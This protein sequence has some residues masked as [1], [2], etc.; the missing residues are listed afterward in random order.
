LKHF[1]FVLALAVCSAPVLAQDPAIPADTEIVS[2]AS[3]LKYCVLKP[4]D[5]TTKP[6]TGD[7]VKMHYTGWLTNG[8]VFDSSVKRNEPFFF[9]LGRGR[10][11]KGWD[12]AVAL[13]TKGEK[14]KITL[15]PELAYGAQGQGK[16]PANSTLIFEIEFLDIAWTYVPLDPAVK[17]VA[18]SGIGYQ[19]L[20]PG[21]GACA[22]DGD[23]A[24][25][26]FAG[27]KP[28]GELITFCEDELMRRGMSPAKGQNAMIGQI[29]TAFFNEALKLVPIGG[30]VRFEVPAA[31]V[32]PS[33][34]PPGFKPDTMVTWEIGVLDAQVLPAFEMPD[35]AKLQK[36][37]SGLG[38]VVIKEGSGKQ[39]KS[40]D[41]VTVN[42]IGWTT[43]G[44]AFD[45]SYAQGQAVPMSLSGVIKGWTEG[46][47][48][49]KEGAIYKFV[50]P[51]EL[52]YGAAGS[53]PVIPPN[54]TLVFQIELVSVP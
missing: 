11:I 24:R 41:R 45:S 42:Y 52:G 46:I 16:I 49:M 36:T 1:F 40:T 51:P 37:A 47:P 21:S 43:D 44:K 28:T 13:M 53:P 3:G 9:E 26:T 31:M 10:V 7:A 2:T 33:R 38:Y 50:I 6:K 8:M 35:P 30:T 15:P 34:L 39:P 14:L 5:G 29:P 18:A 4:G 32:W 48:L 20:R 22:K 54:A 25:F 17:K 27:W 19:L 23:I 12:E